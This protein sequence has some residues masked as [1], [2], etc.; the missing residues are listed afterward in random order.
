MLT[1]LREFIKAHTKVLLGAGA[2]LLT[3]IFLTP[4]V[5]SFSDFRTFV[6]LIDDPNSHYNINENPQSDAELAT[7]TIPQ[8]TFENISDDSFFP[9]PKGKIIRINLFTMQ[10]KQYENGE[11]IGE[12]KIL[13]KG[14]KGSIWETPGGNY[15]V[16]NKEEDYFSERANAWLPFSIQLFGNYF[17]HGIPHNNQGRNYNTS[18]AEG[19]IRLSNEDASD[20]F[21]WADGETRVSIYSDS[22]LKPEPISTE[23]VYITQDGTVRPKV[24]AEAYLVADV[25]TGE[26]ILQKNKD[27]ILPIASLTKLM[28]AVVSLNTMNQFEYATVSKRAANINGV[29]NLRPGEQIELSNLLNPLLLVSSNSSAEV[30]AEHKG[31]EKFIETMNQEA[32]NLKMSNTSFEDPSGLSKNNTSTAYD[33]F[34]LAQHISNEKAFLWDITKRQTYSAQGHSWGNISQFLRDPTYVGGKGGSTYEAKLTHLGV[35]SLPLS[36]KTPRNIAIIVLRSNDRFT[37]TKNI[38]SYLKS[39]V[40]YGKT[41]K[42]EIAEPKDKTHEVSMRF[43][44]DIMLDRGVLYSVDKNYA[45]DFSKLFENLGSYKDSDIFFAN[46]EGPVSDKGTDM[47]NLYSFRMNPDVLP[48]LKNAGL[49]IV[50]FANNHVGD[51]REDAF[52]DTRKRLDENGILYTGAG[53]NSDLSTTPTIIE[54]NGL[55]IGF[56]GFSDVGPNWLNATKEKS[57]INILDDATFDSIVKNAKAQVDVLVTSF[58]WGIEYSKHTDRQTEFA[59]RA[60]DDGATLVIGHH[61]HVVQDVEIYRGGLIAYSLGNFIFDQGFSKE[62]MQGLTLEVVLD[63]D[64]KYIKRYKTYNTIQDST[65]RPSAPIPV[66]L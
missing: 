29:S 40:V 23:S 3:V 52:N 36:D 43:V 7:E 2:L 45:G 66:S 10:L 63:T 38:L 32:K 20:L 47:R 18:F 12:K 62:T 54:K 39:R 65:F 49:D 22:T 27:E 30:I 16:S 37:D 24:S 4:F 64:E 55:K 46:L 11:L 1:S 42:F 44:G 14:K 31:R 57:G 60:I 17:I 53:D 61:P 6:R 56:I 19:C 28:T 9:T 34:L 5:K 8:I 26:I 21:T 15:I 58:H 33:L 50:S 13:S 25:D 59:H 41:G 51:W 48:I 35:W